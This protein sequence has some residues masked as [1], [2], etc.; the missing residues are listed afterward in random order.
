MIKYTPRSPRIKVLRVLVKLLEKYPDEAINYVDIRGT[1]SCS[2]YYGTLTFAP[3]NISL[4][5]NWDCCW[6]AKQVGLK[7]YYGMP[8]QT[9]AAQIYDYQCFEKFEV[10]N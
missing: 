3:G 6:K 2:R 9:K 1:S 8:D 5:F 10:L 4:E 7:T